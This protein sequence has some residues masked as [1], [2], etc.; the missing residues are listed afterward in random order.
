MV[1]ARCNGPNGPWIGSVGP[2]CVRWV[3]RLAL[4]TVAEANGPET[5]EK[6]V[7][8]PTARTILETSHDKYLV[9]MMKSY[10]DPERSLGP[11]ANISLIPA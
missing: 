11:D 2:S 1:H 5:R 7:A 10:G 3:Y 6:R 4:G 8:G 9:I